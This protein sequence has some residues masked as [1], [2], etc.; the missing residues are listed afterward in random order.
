VITMFER[1][2]QWM[3]RLN[4]TADLNNLPHSALTFEDGGK[5]R[6]EIPE[7]ENPG[8]F[9]VMIE[10]ANKLGV[11]VHRVSQ[12]TGIMKLSDKDLRQMAKIGAEQ[13]IEVFLFIGIRGDTGMGAQARSESGGSTRKRLQGATQMLYALE[14]VKRAIDAGIRGFLISDEGLIWV[15][16]QLRELGEIPADVVIKTSVSMGYGTPAAAKVLET[17]G[18]NS[19]N[20]PVDLSLG[21]IAAFR[22][23]IHVPMDLYIEA[24]TGM[25][26]SNRFYELQDIVNIASPVH[27]KFGLSTEELTDPIGIHTQEKADLQVRER[28]RLAA[29][30][31]EILSNDGYMSFMSPKIKNRKGVPVTA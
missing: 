13:G 15:L 23:S 11:P 18:I 2:N 12:G 10:E 5:F 24:P 25:G 19:F 21:T 29:I 17:L 28:I 4:L 14:D 9:E 3:K 27:L 30:G 31:L 8:V 1:P 22:H 7:V 6:I 16:S 26:G 20:L